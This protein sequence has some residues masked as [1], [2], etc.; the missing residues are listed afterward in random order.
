M[1][2]IREGVIVG[3]DIVDYK[4]DSIDPDNPERT[5]EAR[6][7]YYRGQ[8]NTYAQGLSASMRIPLEMINTRL[9]FVGAGIVT[10][11]DHH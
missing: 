6:C 3:A 1:L 8:L 9:A 4:T 5:V 7:D 10:R 11:V 2:I